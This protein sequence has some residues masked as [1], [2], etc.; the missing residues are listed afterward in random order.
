MPRM[1]EEEKMAVPACKAKK[2][3]NQALKGLPRAFY[4]GETSGHYNC[5]KKGVVGVPY[6]RKF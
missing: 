2:R 1:K 6:K 4:K 3:P 5:D